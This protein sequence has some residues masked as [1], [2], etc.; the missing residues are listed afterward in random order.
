[1]RSPPLRLAT[2]RLTIDKAKR[3]GGQ[4]LREKKIEYIWDEVNM[5]LK[6]IET[7]LLKLSS[8][9]KALIVSKLL[10]SLE[11]EDS[12]DIENL[13]IDEA[14]KRYSQI[15]NN[16]NLLFEAAEVIKEAKAKYK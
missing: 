11:G 13:W 15:I 1:M 4:A 7:E 9:E 10:E 6:N 14:V 8:K 3:V 2:I 5:E 16:K 12:T